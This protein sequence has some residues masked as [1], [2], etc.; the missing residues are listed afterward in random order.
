L[1]DNGTS[2]LVLST[3]AFSVL[4]TIWKLG[5][6]YSVRVTRNG[7]KILIYVG[8]LSTEDFHL[9]SLDFYVTKKLSMI[10]F[11]I[12]IAYSVYSWI[13]T[14]PSNLYSWLISTLASCV[15][16][17]GLNFFFPANNFRIFY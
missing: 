8:S 2:Y 7:W 4:L 3:S 12:L 13:Q 5:K 9:S 14:P 11:P 10:L 6:I 1:Y 15:Y 17:F 16:L